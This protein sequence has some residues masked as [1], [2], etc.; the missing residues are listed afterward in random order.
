MDRWS[1]CRVGEWT[2]GADGGEREGGEGVEREERTGGTAEESGSKLMGVEES[3][4]R[5]GLAIF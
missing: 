2:G 3:V 4:E 1:G 5:R